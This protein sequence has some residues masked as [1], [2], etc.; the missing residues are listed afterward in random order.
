MARLHLLQQNS[1]T[2]YS[3]VAHAPTP[4]GSNLAG[5]LWT[6]CLKNAGPPV[7]VLSVGNGAGQI[8]QSESNQVAAGTLVEAQFPWQ[9]D[10]AWTTQQRTADLAV[11]AQQSIDT[12]ISD[13]QDRFRLYG[14]TVA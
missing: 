11:R 14:M 13:M 9:D 6:D 3:A 12:A 2:M 10:P 1:H 8:T 4:A 7:S 5:V